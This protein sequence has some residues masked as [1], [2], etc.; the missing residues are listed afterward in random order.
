MAKNEEKALVKATPSALAL[1]DYIEPKDADDYIDLKEIQLP[2]LCVAQALSPEVQKGDP[3]RI[4]GLE[5]GQMFSN[6]L[7]TNFGEGPLEVVVVRREQ[8][9]AIEF[10]PRNSQEGQGVKDPA[11]P[12]YGKRDPRN[13]PRTE[14]GASGEKPVATVFHEYV[15]FVLAT[16]EPIVLSFKSTSTSAATRLNTLLSVNAGK[17]YART[18]RISAVQQRNDFGPFFVF[19][20]EQGRLIDK[21]T[22]EYAKS[23]R[24][25]LTGRALAAENLDSERD[26]TDADAPF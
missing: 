13:D 19:R 5:V 26:T 18:Y 7:Q 25:S 6:V 9:R 21:D 12:Y 2:R 4:D 10:W 14:F 23:L 24:E 1:P 17:P 3:K 20:V 8:P 22:Y 11:V 15:A 16:R